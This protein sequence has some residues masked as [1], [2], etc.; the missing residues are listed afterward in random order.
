MNDL[1]LLRQYSQQGSQEAFSVL[2]SRYVDL[3]YSAAR[4]QVGSPDLASEVAQTVFLDLAASARKI[5]PDTHLASWL[6]VASRRRAIDLVRREVSRQ[7]REQAALEV[8]TMKSSAPSWSELEPLLD[9]AMASLDDTDRKAILL[10]F[11]ENKNLDEV[12]CALGSSEDAAQ[13][14]VSRAV[15]RLRSYFAKRGVAT[16]AAALMTDLSAHAVLPA[17][18]GLG[19]AVMTSVAS[20]GASAAI[21]VHQ[22]GRVFVAAVWEKALLALILS[23]AIGFVFH[24]VHVLQGQ[25]REIASLENLWG[26]LRNENHKLLSE[27]DQ[28]WARSAAAEEA[29]SSGDAEFDARIKA[30]LV[31]I[32]QVKQ[33]L[34]ED[35]A[36]QIPELRFLSESE[37]FDIVQNQVSWD[38]D[39]D[40]RTAFVSA[41]TYAKSRF[42]RMLYESLD[43]YFAANNGRLPAEM[44]QLAPFFASAVEDALLARYEIRA[45]GSIPELPSNAVV[46]GE[47][48]SNR[49]DPNKDNLEEI[50]L[51]SRGAKS[52]RPWPE[53]KILQSPMLMEAVQAY[54]DAH[55]GKDPDS[56]HPE[57]LAPYFLDAEAGKAFVEIFKTTT[58]P[59]EFS[60]PNAVGEANILFGTAH[61]GARPAKPEDLE[62]YFQNP[63]DAAKYLLAIK[64]GRL[65]L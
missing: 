47:K 24:Q 20:H 45:T 50:Y 18:I 29:T 49:I 36:Q 54:R 14:R 2:V 32:A 19:S 16:A 34:K 46:I 27:R 4:R 53:M 17:P 64:E 41:R 3:V 56:N 63:N 37:W 11:F 25:R 15:E 38:T 65:K 61:H 33:R 44:V 12:G 5:K 40:F 55:E 23:V 62:L 22:A 57:Q 43:E 9:E 35:P 6:Y 59:F 48:T 39:E 8:S 26:N 42:L 51:E 28:A 60:H 10:R 7:R 1:D 58:N 31:R 13:K 30:V 52:V 21:V